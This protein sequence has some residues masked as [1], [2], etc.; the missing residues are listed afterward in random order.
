[1]MDLWGKGNVAGIQWVEARIG[2]ETSMHRHS[3]GAN[4]DLT[5][6]WL[7]IPNYTPTGKEPSFKKRFGPECISMGGWEGMKRAQLG[8]KTQEGARGS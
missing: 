5:S 7:R 8:W 2:V 1:M 6:K 4:K 3:P